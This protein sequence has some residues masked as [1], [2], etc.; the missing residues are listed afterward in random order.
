M[1]FIGTLRDIQCAIEND[2]QS[3]GVSVYY[4]DIAEHFE[5]WSHLLS[6][7][8]PRV[9]DVEM[10][11]RETDD[12]NVDN[13]LV[14]NTILW[15]MKRDMIIIPSMNVSSCTINDIGKLMVDSYETS[16]PITF[17]PQYLDKILRL[18]VS[19]QKL[20]ALPNFTN[21][22][23][24]NCSDNKIT[25]IPPGMVSLEKLVC[26]N[27]P[28]THIPS[29]LIRLEILKCNGTRLIEIPPELVN[30]RTLN[31]YGTQIT[32]LPD[33]LVKLTNIQLPLDVDVYKLMLTNPGVISPS[34]FR[35]TFAA[36][37]RQHFL[38]NAT[39]SAKT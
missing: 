16:H 34:R 15:M 23:E 19:C 25:E 26:D 14:C 20:T 21:L 3:D 17:I 30:L 18:E 13:I 4:Q 22:V 2:Q 33:T 1:V 31:F 38:I 12:Y 36:Q 11:N 9:I 37:E 32:E 35:V 8:F 10:M 27:C 29:T 6:V 24:L 7:Y 28:I 5:E 39:K